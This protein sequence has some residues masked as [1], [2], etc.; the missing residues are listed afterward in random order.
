[1][2]GDILPYM[3]LPPFFSK[4]ILVSISYL[5]ERALLCYTYQVTCGRLK[6]DVAYQLGERRDGLLGKI[7]LTS[8]RI[9]I[10]YQQ[11]VNNHVLKVERVSRE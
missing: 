7:R 6:K 11:Q 3:S 2:S 4:L 1:V 10:P 8:P 9:V 5:A